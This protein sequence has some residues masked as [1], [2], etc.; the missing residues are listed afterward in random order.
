MMGPPT[1]PT[2]KKVFGQL[3]CALQNFAGLHLM[4]RGPEPDP[5]PTERGTGYGKEGEEPSPVRAG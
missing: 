2:L 3:D 1:G 5:A 4:A